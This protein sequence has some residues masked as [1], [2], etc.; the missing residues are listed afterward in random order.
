MK[1]GGEGSEHDRLIKGLSE[2]MKRY[3][4]AVSGQVFA[5]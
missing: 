2:E 3:E 4:Q 1:Q 5:E